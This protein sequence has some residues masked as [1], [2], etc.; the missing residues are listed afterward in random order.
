MKENHFDF[1][2][3]I[4]KKRNSEN[5]HDILFQMLTLGNFFILAIEKSYLT[6]IKNN[7]QN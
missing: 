2:Q 5:S 3:P 4:S 6:V 1:T 7:F